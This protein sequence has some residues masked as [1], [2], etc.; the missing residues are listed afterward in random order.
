MLYFVKFEDL[1]CYFCDFFCFIYISAS[2]YPI[3]MKIISNFR[4]NVALHSHRIEPVP[5]RFEPVLEPRFCPVLVQ[6]K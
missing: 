4:E 1:T 6:Q 5:D 3:W 2:F